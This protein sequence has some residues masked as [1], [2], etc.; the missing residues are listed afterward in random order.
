MNAQQASWTAGCSAHVERL[1][2]LVEVKHAVGGAF[3]QRHELLREQAE[4]AVIPAAACAYRKGASAE[5]MLAAVQEGSVS[6][7]IAGT[8][9]PPG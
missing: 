4:R 9:L 3:H 6:S 1:G 2:G 5:V 7:V 8:V